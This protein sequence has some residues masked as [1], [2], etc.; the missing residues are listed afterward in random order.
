MRGRKKKGKKK[1]LWQAG[2]GRETAGSGGLQ[3]MEG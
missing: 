3:E 2:G 1:R